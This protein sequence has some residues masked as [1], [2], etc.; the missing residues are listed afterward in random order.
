MLIRLITALCLLAA[1]RSPAAD[2][3]AG[4][5][6]ALM[7]PRNTAAELDAAISAAR[8][9]GISKQAIL[10]AKLMW[11]LRNQ[12]IG[13]LTSILPDLDEAALAFRAEA[14]PNHFTSVENYRGMLS[15]LRALV[16]DDEHDEEAFRRH[17]TDAI[18]RFPQQ[19]GTFGTVIAQFQIRE[20]MARVTLDLSLPLATSASKV[21]SLGQTLGTDKALLL[22]FWSTSEPRSVQS[23]H[24]FIQLAPA[25]APYGIR[26]AGL[27]LDDIETAEKIRTEQG[28]PCAWLVEP[29]DRPLTNLLEITSVP[30]LVLI[31]T[32]GRILFHGPPNDPVLWKALKRVAPTLVPPKR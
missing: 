27:G 16:A 29:S 7:A 14:S 24:D 26:T 10:E 31:S 2:F 22:L 12:D 15:Y 18:W 11:G 21:T 20:K 13:Y 6:T 28:A 23:I 32:Q 1:L 17:I 3:E 9:E 19:G 5:I 4:L 25:L 8:T 30:R